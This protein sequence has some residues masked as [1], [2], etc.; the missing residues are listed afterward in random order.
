MITKYKALALASGLLAGATAT[1][2]PQPVKDFVGHAA[3]SDVRISPT[4]EYLAM[5]V[6]R[7]DQDV[8]VVLRTADL[9]LMKVNQLPDEK[10]VGTFRWTSPDRLLFNSVKKFGTYAA[11]FNTGEWYAVN[12]DGSD[13]R[14][15][16]FYGARD[17][18]QRGKTVGAERFTLLDDLRDNEKEVLMVSTYQR[19]NSGGGAEVVSMDTR[20]GRR[21]PL[22]K[23][24]RDNCG[25]ALDEAKKV[26]FAVCYDTE[27]GSD[28]ETYDSWTE[29]YRR[30]DDGKWTLLNRSQDSGKDVT[31]LGT[32]GDGRIYATQS[33]RKSPEAFGVLNNETGA[34]ETL[35]HDPV[36]DPLT[37][38][39]ASDNETIL[40]VVTMAGGPKVTLIEDEHPDAKIY[41]SLAKAFPGQFVNFSTATDDGKQI[42]VSV[43]SDRNPGE[44][45][46]YDRDAGK[47]RFLLQRRKQIDP[48]RMGRIEPFK[49]TSRDGLLIHG[50]LT[51]PNGAD[52]KNMPLI[53]NPHGGPMGPRDYWG[54][55]PEAQ[56][57]ASRGYA[58]MQVNY[59]GSG[60]FGKAFQD[61]AYGQWAQGIMND[62]IDAV[63]WSIAEG[64]VDKNRVCIYGG[65]FGGY[66][67]LMAPVRAPEMF[68]CAFGYVGLYDAQIQFKLSD[69]SKRDDGLR[70]LR[71]AFGESRAEQDAMSPI[72]FADEIKLPV[73]LAAG[74]RDPRCPPEHTEA[75]YEALE[76]SGNQPE[77]MIIESGEMHGFYGEEARVKLYSQMLSFFDRHIGKSGAAQAGGS[78]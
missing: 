66:S 51:I 45:Y 38:I 25:I 21:K 23:A 58:T 62:L 8:L 69:T 57:F 17:A 70:Y 54:Y 3:Y 41:A 46:L 59:R 68:K 67:S 4:G 64:K 10:S 48:E 19:S 24:P 52:G 6:D 49:F 26:R 11:P 47:A 1:A 12:A 39:T 42:V 30:G 65:S 44:L 74:A 22:G 63:N 43:Y 5:T 16:I 36:S 40:G 14:P 27:H 7:G 20:S 77:G 15:L 56:L 33:D 71:R 78:H 61:R 53:L 73:F 2:E 75:M 18:T 37:Y 35:F 32:A 72:T 60:G 76:E 31:V 34:F 55:N 9:S 28:D 29:L 13:P 50:Y